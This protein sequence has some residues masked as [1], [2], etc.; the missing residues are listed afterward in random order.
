M[1]P[2]HGRKRS[3]SPSLRS[4]SGD[5]DTS[6]KKLKTNKRARSASPSVRHRSPTKKAKKKTTA[7]S[8]GDTASSPIP[9]LDS[10]TETKDQLAHR[11]VNHRRMRRASSSLPHRPPIDSDKLAKKSE[12]THSSGDT[13]SVLPGEDGDEGCKSRHDNDNDHY[14]VLS[15]PRLNESP[16]TDKDQQAHKGIILPAAEKPKKRKHELVLNLPFRLLWIVVGWNW[17][18]GKSKEWRLRRERK[19]INEGI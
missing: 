15:L 18:N 7:D 13:I 1:I 2:S 19:S 8:N 5:G 9:S 12:M 3:A 17:K 16:R 6:S 14:P 11:T 4:R 10:T